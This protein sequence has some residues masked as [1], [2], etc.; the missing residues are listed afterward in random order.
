MCLHHP[1]SPGPCAKL[2]LSDQ[3]L[4]RGTVSVQ[5]SSSQCGL[6]DSTTERKKGKVKTER[7]I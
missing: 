6:N 5:V 4:W 2:C 7:I 3:S 1:F